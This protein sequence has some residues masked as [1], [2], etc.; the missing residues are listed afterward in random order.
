MSDLNNAINQ[1]Q[2]MLSSEEGKRDIENMINSLGIGTGQPSE[3]VGGIG[4]INADSMAKMRDIMDAF[5]RHDDPRSQLLLALKPYLSSAR[6]ARIDT[7]I[8]LLSL[9]K[10]PS[11]MKIMRG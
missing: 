7:A 1:L 3:N 2:N 6:G 4:G 11:I 5:Q 9:G 8:M 10:I